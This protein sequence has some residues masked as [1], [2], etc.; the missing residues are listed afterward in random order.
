MADFLLLSIIVGYRL[1][2]TPE[3]SRGRH[4]GEDAPEPLYTLHFKGGG[5]GLE[6]GGREGWE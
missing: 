1:P 2:P 6:V 4:C 5:V 3:E